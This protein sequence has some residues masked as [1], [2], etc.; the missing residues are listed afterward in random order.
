MLTV[1]HNVIKIWDS[2]PTKIQV[3]LDHFTVDP[4]QKPHYLGAKI[5]SIQGFFFVVQLPRLL[6]E[7]GYQKE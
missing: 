1:F 4:S 3:V 6:E 2:N 7:E 5:E